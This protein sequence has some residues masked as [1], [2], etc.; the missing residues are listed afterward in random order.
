MRKLIRRLFILS[1]LCL[2]LYFCNEALQSWNDSPIVTSVSLRDIKQIPFPSVTICAPN[3]SWKWAGISKV[4]S[5]YDLHNEVG[6]DIANR[7]TDLH[8]LF[9]KI[10]FSRPTFEKSEEFKKVSNL[11][12]LQIIK[13]QLR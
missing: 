11:T 7:G 10:V 1:Q 13:A 8:E 4:M 5:H 12:S 2:A 3:K 6:K 9:T